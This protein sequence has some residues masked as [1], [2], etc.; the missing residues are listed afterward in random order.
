MN[1]FIDKTL[2]TKEIFGLSLIFLVAVLVR[3]KINFSTEYIP[4]GNGAYY[5]VAVRNI[6]ETGSSLY[7]DFPLV[8]YLEAMLAFILMKVGAVNMNAA[9]DLSCRLIDSIIPALSIIP[10]YLTVK[11]L[12]YKENSLLPKLVISSFSVLYIYFFML[13]SDFQKNALGLLWLNWLLYWILKAHQE[14]SIRNMLWASTFFILTAVT[15]YGCISV[16][17]VIVAA[18]IIVPYLLKLSWKKLVV[19]TVAALIVLGITLLFLYLIF[20]FRYS[21]LIEAP[22]KIFEQ[23]VLKFILKKEPVISPIDIITIILSNAI[24][25]F[26]LVKYIKNYKVINEAS[27]SYILTMIIISFFLSSPL[28]S[29]NYAQRI[30]FIS[31]IIIVPLLAF[32]YDMTNTVKTRTY[33]IA[34]LYVVLASSVILSASRKNYSNMSASLYSELNK[35]KLVLPKDEKSVIV[36]RHGLEY[37]STWIFQNMAIR[38][39]ALSEVYWRWYNKVYFIVQKKDKT[40]FGPAGVFGKPFSEP[41]IPENAKQIY[42]SYSFDLFISLEEPRDFSIFSEKHR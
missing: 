19:A 5:L 4:G 21:T 18:S 41:A 29:F 35:M 24:A 3:L 42:S 20:P 36:A 32:C 17:L 23:P 31:Y 33:I 8:F 15:H 1:R 11:R 37:W 7:R 13:V 12:L 26:S 28:I 34:A 38:Q 2:R 16:A 30:Y 22:N 9:I 25:L 10:S 6:L 40:P 39:E 14:K 27:R